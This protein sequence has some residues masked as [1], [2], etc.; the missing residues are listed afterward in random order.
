MSQMV[1]LGLSAMSAPMSGV[2]ESDMSARFMSN[3]AQ[4]ED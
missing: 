3:E 2:P 4:R 1:K